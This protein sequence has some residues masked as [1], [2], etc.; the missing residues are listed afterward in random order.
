MFPLFVLLGTTALLAGGKFTYLFFYLALLLFLLPYLWLRLSL[1]HLTGNIEV[2]AAY[3]EVGQHLTVKYIIENSPSGRF[4]YLELTNMIG[5]SFQAPAEE[6]IIGLEAGEN[7]VYRR[8]VLCTRRGKYD[9]KSFQVKTGDPF[10]FFQLTKPLAAGE[11]IKVYPRLRFFPEITLSARQHYGELP[12]RERHFEHF[13]QVSDLR[14]WREGDSMKKVH[15]KQS[16]R[17]DRIVVKNFEHQGDTTLNIFVDMC[18]T[19]YRHDSEHKL[20]DL[21][22]ETAASLLFFNLRENVPVEIFSEPVPAMRLYGRHPRDYREIMDR[23]ISL[24]PRGKTA[25]SLFVHRWSYYL[26]P[27]SSLYLLT[28][29]LELADAAVFLRLKQ[30]GFFVVLFYLAPE[31]PGPREKSLLDKAEKAGI[32]VHILHPA[33]GTG[34][35]RQAL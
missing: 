14:E 6:R 12:V 4:P 24:A 29:R 8:E 16:A 9:L 19:S 28:P 11:E 17:Q 15:W 33:E 26:A 2:S 18:G 23:V 31:E 5:S 30:R 21:A 32:K 1:K 13:S 20:E 25:F 22:V 35:D 27:T 10:G 34:D 7:A 3:A